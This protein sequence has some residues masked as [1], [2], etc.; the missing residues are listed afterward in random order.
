[1]ILFFSVK[2]INFEIIKKFLK[3]KIFCDKVIC[4]ISSKKNIYRVHKE[5]VIKKNG[6]IM[7]KNDIEKMI[8]FHKM[9]KKSLPFEYV[10]FKNDYLKNSKFNLDQLKK[11]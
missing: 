4:I 3:N 2:K 5:R 1:M 10:N 11:L 6:W 9:I 7:S 8:H